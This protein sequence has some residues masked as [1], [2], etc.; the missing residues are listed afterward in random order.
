M[1]LLLFVGLVVNY[2]FLYV[3]L[4]LTDYALIMGSIG[5]TIILGAT[6][7]FT[8]NIDWYGTSTTKT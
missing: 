6:M 2:G 4:Q 7:Y 3:I 1:T 5:L 8:R